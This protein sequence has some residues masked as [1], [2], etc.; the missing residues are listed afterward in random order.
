M[1]VEA[2]GASQT[3][4]PARPTTRQDVS[5][6]VERHQQRCENLKD[7]QTVSYPK[8]PCYVNRNSGHYNWKSS[9]FFSVTPENTEG[10]VKVINSGWMVSICRFSVTIIFLSL[11]LARDWL[12]SDDLLPP[13]PVQHVYSKSPFLFTKLYSVTQH[14]AVARRSSLKP[15]IFQFDTKC[16][17]H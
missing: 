1:T 15:H 12:R 7:T 11:L 10:L 16:R 2:L 4:G 17:A 5:P 9:P 8:T 14:K 6:N 13:L 3:S